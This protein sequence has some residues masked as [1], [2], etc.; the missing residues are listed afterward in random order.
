MSSTMEEMSKISQRFENY[1]ISKYEEKYFDI[2]VEKIKNK[3]QILDMKDNQITEFKDKLL[4]VSAVNALLTYITQ[5]QK[6]EIENIN[7]IK[8]YN[9]TRYMALD[10]TARRNLEIHISCICTTVC[11]FS[12]KSFYIIY[13]F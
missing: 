2:D 13:F 8:I 3:H 4:L 12:Y 11:D 10:I 1:Y 5:M 7:A 6:M 9:T